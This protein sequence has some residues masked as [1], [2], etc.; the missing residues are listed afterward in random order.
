VS[1]RRTVFADILKPKPVEA[2]EAEPA[3][4]P[5][6]PNREKEAPKAKSPKLNKAVNPEYMKLT[7]YIPRDLHFEI[8]TA[9]AADQETDQ[10]AYIERWLRESLERR[11]SATGLQRNNSATPQ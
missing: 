6:P 3:R 1:E 8:K 9:M 10:S 4:A 2:E 11:Q 5:L 7:A